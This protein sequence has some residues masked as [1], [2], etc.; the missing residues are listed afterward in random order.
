MTQHAFEADTGKIL[1]IVIHSLYSNK[2][3]FLRELISNAS[4]AVDKLRYMAVSDKSLSD[5]TDEFH[6]SLLADAKAKTLTISDN[7][8]GMSDEEMAQSL[9]TIARSGTKSFMEALNNSTDKSEN[10]SLIGQFG[11]GFYSAFMVADKVEVLSRK[12]GTDAA[13]LWSSDGRSGYSITPS[14]KADHGTVITLYLKK[15]AKDYLE[16]MRLGH[17][18]KT[19]ADHINYPVNFVDGQEVRRLNSGSA[20]WAKPKSEITEEDYEAFFADMG[21]GFGKPLLTLHNVSEGAVSF[22]NLLCIPQ[23][24]P[25]DLFDPAR[26]PKVKLYINRVFITDDCAALIPAWLRFVRGIVDTADI[27]LNV[28]RE[29]LQ[30]NKTLDK[31]GKAVVRRI[32]SELKKMHDKKREDYDNLWEQFGIVLK[33]GMY[34]DAD[35]REKLLEI[36]RFRTSAGAE[37]SGLSDYVSRMAE[38]QD[39]IYYLSAESLT[40]AELSPHLEGFKARGIEVVYFTDPVDEFWLPLVG[41]FEGKPFAS[42]TKGGVDLDNFAKKDAASDADVVE[43]DIS[44][45]IAKMKEVLG[46]S[47]ADIRVS[48][49]LTDSPACLVAD[50]NGMDIQMQRMMRA[51]DPNF[52]EMPRILELNPNHQLVTALQDMTAGK[53][54]ADLVEDAAHMLFDQSLILEG[55]TPSDVASFSQRMVRLMTRGLKL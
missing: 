14:E 23:M 38:G 51:H 12:A 10:L 47:V 11:V 29:L 15:D 3:I 40:Q 33:E 30:H 43:T 16:E 24:R 18:I 44:D 4:D 1:D 34:E 42:I 7:G 19:Y 35:N 28:S 20:L 54:Q 22:T 6:I 17:I 41:E 5:L 26:K 55:K 37:L 2:E 25:Y 52:T 31:I 21:A 32:L 39:A 48:K 50:E 45:L 49:T 36:A 53:Q 13:F 8:I 46:G 27:D 9:G